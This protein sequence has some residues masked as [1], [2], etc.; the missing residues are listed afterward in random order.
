MKQVTT[1]LTAAVKQGLEQEINA[2]RAQVRSVLEDK[3]KGEAVVKQKIALL[4]DAAKELNETNA[5]LSDLVFELANEK[6]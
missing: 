3:R 2:V 5:A 1:N 6:A 4:E